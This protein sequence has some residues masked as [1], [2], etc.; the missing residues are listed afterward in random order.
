L[1]PDKI[2]SAKKET[3]LIDVFSTLDR[4]LPGKRRIKKRRDFLDIQSSG[5]K[6]GSSH[7]TL[8]S[9]ASALQVAD[10]ADSRIGI[11]VTKKVDKRA[12]GRNRLKRLVREEFR[13][14]RPSFKKKMD[15]VVIC[16]K[17]SSELE[18]A[19]IRAQLRLLFEKARLLPRSKR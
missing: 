9:K 6:A 16:K 18:A 5:I 8:V 1:I 3:N 19:E 12:V 17:G 14:L 11:T 10:Q 13:T 4:C 15:L 7:F 2:F